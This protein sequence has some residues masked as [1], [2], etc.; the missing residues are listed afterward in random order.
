MDQNL[1]QGQE[2][3]LQLAVDLLSEFTARKVESKAEGGFDQDFVTRL[4][5]IQKIEELD[6]ETLFDTLAV[7]CIYLQDNSAHKIILSGRLLPQFWGVLER[8][9][10]MKAYLPDQG[11]MYH[12]YLVNKAEIDHR[13][14]HTEVTRQWLR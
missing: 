10:L 3:V 14:W 5:R 12:A 7:L 2:D 8:L 9:N 11:N 4:L 6:E 1:W 13:H